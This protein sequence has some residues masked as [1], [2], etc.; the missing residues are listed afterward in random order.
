MSEAPSTP[1]PAPGWRDG[2]PQRLW[3]VDHPYYCNHGNFYAPGND[4]PTQHYK[5]LGAF[6]YENAD[7]DL[8]LN[9]VFRWDWKEG[10]DEDGKAVAFNGDENYRNGLLSIYF[11]GQRKGLYRWVTVEVCRADEPAVIGYLQPRL[12]Y[13]MRLWAPLPPPRRRGDERAHN[14]RCDP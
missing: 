7:A 9:L 3:E 11:M 10:E 5:S 1:T 4:Q 6:L 13:L 2:R 14:R 8:D 12:D